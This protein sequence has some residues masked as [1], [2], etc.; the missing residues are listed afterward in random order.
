MTP[1]EF[2]T[3]KMTFKLNIERG[4]QPSHFVRAA[5]AH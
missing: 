4:I 3:F 2:V 1:I 5:F